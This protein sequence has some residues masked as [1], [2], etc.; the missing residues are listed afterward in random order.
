MESGSA[1]REVF[2]DLTRKLN[3]LSIGIDSDNQTQGDYFATLESPVYPIQP[4]WPKSGL[5][6]AWGFI[7][8]FFG[9]IFIAAIREYFDRSTLHANAIA[10]RLGVP[11]LGTLP[12]FPG[13]K[14]IPL[15]RLKAPG[16]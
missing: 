2:D 10:L 11:M 6:I 1:N 13:Q 4:A 5:I 9:S 7:M 16:K 8:G 15:L 12:R 14:D 3:Y